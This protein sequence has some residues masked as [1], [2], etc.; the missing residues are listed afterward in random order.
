MFQYYRYSNIE[1]NWVICK[2]YEI[3]IGVV[4]SRN[5]AILVRILSCALT[6]NRGTE[7]YMGLDFLTSDIINAEMTSGSCPLL[8]QGQTTPSLLK[9]KFKNPSHL[10]S[11]E[12]SCHACIL[13]SILASSFTWRGSGHC[14]KSNIKYV[15]TGF[16]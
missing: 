15:F 12:K 5:G 10:Y 14:F 11:R 7:T 3:D 8:K 1:F 16:P 13:A 2:W 6:P 9:Y 4:I